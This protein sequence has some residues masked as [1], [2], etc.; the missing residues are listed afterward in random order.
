M[1]RTY[2]DSG[3]GTVKMKRHNAFWWWN[4]AICNLCQYTTGWGNNYVSVGD[5]L[6]TNPLKHPY[7]SEQLIETML[8]TSLECPLTR[9][10]RTEQY[11]LL[12]SFSQLLEHRSANG[13]YSV[14][15]CLTF[16]P[17]L[18]GQSPC[19]LYGNFSSEMRTIVST[20]SPAGIRIASFVPFLLDQLQNVGTSWEFITKYR[21]RRSFNGRQLPG[22]SNIWME[23][24][25]QFQMLTCHSNLVIVFQRFINELF[26]LLLNSEV[27]I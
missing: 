13:L 24:P 8:W 26:H 2:C 1:L 23:L 4:R 17:S 19:A 15:N 21:S 10:N 3:T 5:N 25:Y 9:G 6:P 7:C 12:V 18:L 16:H 20:P 27:I 22:N 11:L 14:L